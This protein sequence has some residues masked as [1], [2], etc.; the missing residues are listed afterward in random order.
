MKIETNGAFKTVSI[1]NQQ[2]EESFPMWLIDF[3]WYGYVALTSHKQV[4]LSYVDYATEVA[5]MFTPS[6]T[7]HSPGFWVGTPGEPKNS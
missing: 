6:E 5:A 7:S 3:L 4:S 1:H 2:I